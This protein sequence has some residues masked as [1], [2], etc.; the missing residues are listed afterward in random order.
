MLALAPLAMSIPRK[1]PMFSII[2]LP[3]LLT[4]SVLF[5]LVLVVA[6]V[7]VPRRRAAGARAYVEQAV[8]VLLVILLA[9][10]TVF[11]YLNRE[12]NWYGTWGDLLANNDI[13]HISSTT[14]G[15][16]LAPNPAPT[17]QTNAQLTDLQRAPRTNPALGDVSADDA[18]G[19]WLSVT[20][21]ATSAST[22]QLSVHALIWLPPGY[23]EDSTRSY[24]VVV[25]F[26]GIPG[27]VS[28]YRDTFHIDRM[29]LDNVREGRMQAPI[30]VFPSVFPRNA[31]TECVDG[32]DGTW[33]TWITTDMRAWITTNL[34]AVNEPAAWATT[35]YSAGGWCASMIAM[36]HPD[37]YSWGISLA[38]YFHA[39]YAPG[40]IQD[41]P[42]D[43]RYRLDQVAEHERP[44]VALWAF[45]G[46]DDQPAIN[47]V[48]DI[49]KSIGAPTTL[50]ANISERGGHR[51]R[52]WMT[53]QRTAFSWLGQVSP[54]FAPMGA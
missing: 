19:Q 48:K 44:A 10:S 11:L 8:V 53:P 4:S 1:D 31:D 41:D 52:M 36:R 28:T 22:T 7:V 24:P 6:L 16:A 12:N 51:P 32:K 23:V 9:L 38:G 15:A 26:P 35:G 30:M 43:A 29:V 5:A 50:V 42:E 27:S 37:Q 18:D 13:G 45:A 39:E 40:Q 54:W 47:D 20:M 34:R 21:A 2:G 49:E 14:Y 17:Q 25:G 33:E 3:V 46:G